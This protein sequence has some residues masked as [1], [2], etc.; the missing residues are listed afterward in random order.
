MKQKYYIAIPAYNEA[1]NLHKFFPGLARAVNMASKDHELEATYICANGCIDNTEELIKRYR[2]RLPKLKIKLLHSEK[3]MNRALCKIIVAIPNQK[4]PVVKVDADVRLGQEAIQIL[5]AELSK[6]RELQIVGGHPKA[7]DYKGKDIKLRLMTNI[8]DIR[9]RYP[10]SQVAAYDVAEFHQVAIA[11]PQ[12]TVTQNF[13]LSS[14]IYFHGR[15]YALRNKSLWNVPEDRIGDDTYL[16]LDT[17]K[18]HGLG[19]IRLRYDANCFYHPSRS[20][21]GHW[22]VYKRIFCD[23]YTLFQLPE[24]QSKKIKDIIKR[25][26]VKLDWNYIKTLPIQIQAYFAC[27]GAIK[28]TFNILFRLSPKYTDSLWTYKVKTN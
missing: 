17:Y 12:P 5:L 25:E 9:S 27:Y 11:D 6:H 22:K 14:R 4:Y 1:K 23:T 18:K 8:L 28:H 20:L 16:T 2:T 10:M 7:E 15:L 13:E 19:C 24:F 21:I 3:G 26:K